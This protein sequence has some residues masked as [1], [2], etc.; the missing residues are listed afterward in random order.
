V[1]RDL[2]TRFAL[3]VVMGAVLG[4]LIDSAWIKYPLLALLGACLGAWPAGLQ[5]GPLRLMERRSDPADG[6]ELCLG[7]AS[8]RLER[9]AEAKRSDLAPR[10]R[11]LWSLTCTAPFG[12]WR[13]P[14]FFTAR[15]EYRWGRVRSWFLVLPLLGDLHFGLTVRNADQT[16]SA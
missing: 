13:M 6:D 7:I 8:W 3:A 14:S 16:A 15:G 4:V 1:T 11:V 12:E 10:P 9:W 5:I 2:A